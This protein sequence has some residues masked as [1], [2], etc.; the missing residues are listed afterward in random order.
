MY[1]E[2]AF[3]EPVRSLCE[4]CQGR[5]FNDQ[6]LSYLYQ[7][8]NISQVL[9]MTV[10]QALDFFQGGKIREQLA[11]LA[12]VGLEYL[13][14]GQ[15]LPTLSGGECQ[16]LK[17]AGLLQQQGSVYILDEPTTGLHPSDVERLQGI[18]D[19]LVDAGNT[20]IVIE[21]NL[22]VIKRADYV[23]DLGPGGGN[24]G[25]RLLYAGP[26][27]GLLDCPASRT[28]ACLRKEIQQ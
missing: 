20:V 28:G 18:L 22:D 5:R 12:R 21:H 13:T 19:Q 15:P 24:Q 26:P 7:G 3:M 4:N 27:A 6:V 16:R 14:L 1:T 17:L 2:L 23:I 25:G 8:K 10:E 9:D 11:M